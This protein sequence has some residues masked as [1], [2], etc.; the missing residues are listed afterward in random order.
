MKILKVRIDGFGHFSGYELSLSPGMNLLFGQNEAGK[1]TLLSFIRA[2]LFGFERRTSPNRYEPTRGEG[3]YGGELELS[4]HFGPLWVK[5][6]GGRKRYE[7]E[8]L[9]RDG[10][11]RVQPERRLAEAL[12]Q[13]SK[14]LFCQVFAFGLDELSSFENLAAQG[15]VSEALFAAGMQGAQRLPRAVEVLTKSSEAIFTPKGQK[16]ELNA[17]L[18]ELEQV[19][20]RIRAIGDRPAQYF[21]A[22]ARRSSV[23]EELARLEGELDAARKRRDALA[24]LSVAAVDLEALERLSA[25]LAELPDLSSFPES[26]LERLEE[27]SRRRAAER[28]ERDGIAGQLLAVEKDRAWLAKAGHLPVGEAELKSALEAFTARLAQIRALP[29]RKAALGERARQADECVRALGLSVDGARLRELELGAAAKGALLTLRERFADAERQL[30]AKAEQARVAATFRAQLEEEVQRLSH[31]MRE[32]PATAAA[33][34][35]RKQAALSRIEAVR[36]ERA[37]IGEQVAEK[38]SAIEALRNAPEPSA[39]ELFPAHLLALA[40]AVLLGAAAGAIWKVGGM[41]AIGGAAVAVALAAILTVVQRRAASSY[42]EQRAAAIEARARRDREVARLSTEI[43]ELNGEDARLD[44]ECRAY[45][46]QAGVSVDADEPALSTRSEELAEELSAVT[47]REQLAKQVEALTVRLNQALRDERQA[48]AD[49]AVAEALLSSLLREL[50]AYVVPRGLPRGLSIQAA[51]DVWNEAAAVRGRL[52]ELDAE[53]KALEADEQACTAAAERVLALAAQCGLE[54]GTAEPYGA[55]EAAAGALSALLQKEGDLAEQ[56]RR[57]EQRREL[58]K[59]QL[60]ARDRALTEVEAAI[61][62]LLEQG[63]C[64]NEEAFR[65]RASLATRFWAAKAAMREAVSRAEAAA[66]RPWAEAA[67]ELAQMGGRA[68][69]EALVAEADRQVSHLEAA[70]AHLAEEKGTLTERM[71]TYE[72]DGELAALRRKEE[73]LLA[74]AQQLAERYAVERLALGLLARA[75]RKFEREQQPK[76]IQLASNVFSELTAGRYRRVFLSAEGKRELSVQDLS[77]REW[78]AEQL[79]RGT[80]EQLY[81]AF[82]LAV[83]EDFGDTR[84]PLPIVV[85]DILVNFDPE[86]TR[87]TLKVLARLSRRHQVIAFTCHPS[88]KELF[89]AEGAHLVEMSARQQLT[90]I[91][92]ANG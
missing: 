52:L 44:A 50:D 17:L 71:A 87:H 80:R 37:R 47:R 67:G 10:E 2:V 70:R 84:L 5:R 51:F 58:L 73:S 77:G 85:D 7:G 15:G 40:C 16:P 43:S 11:N 25:E 61:G 24:R 69:L 86:R 12:G 8:L 54:R 26:G 48:A 4:T 22:R 36:L 13:V 38:R 74:S 42:R 57:L 89:R 82:R 81:L 21:E 9:L 35:R 88:L 27:L 72:N 49:R 39:R 31:E 53:R 14:E 83:I 63:G 79:S 65:A 34:V 33:E 76:V 28:A 6:H 62:E 60:A 23:G 19:R 29:S 68:S 90:L 30:Q 46:E 1:S 32:L 45:C 18:S 92:T 3:P 56:R 20:D 91:S 78:S 64:A 41:T 55:A 75:R 59:A 66:G